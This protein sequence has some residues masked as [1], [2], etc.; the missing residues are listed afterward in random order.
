MSSLVELRKVQ[1]VYSQVPTPVLAEVNL[2]ITPG[3]R[4][5]ILGASG[6]GKTT[7]LHLLGL[8]LKADEGQ[9]L[10]D[11]A[12]AQVWSEHKR[13][14]WRR[15]NLGYVFQD[16]GLIPELTLEE[17]V[18]L[19]LRIAGIKS[20]AGLAKELLAQVGL[21]GRRKSFPSEVSGGESQRVAIAR[22]LIGQPKIVLADE[23]TGNLQRQQGEEI[24][25]LFRK[26]Q[27]ELGFSLVVATH[28]E[29]I[30][31]LLQARVFRLSSGS[32]ECQGNG[33]NAQ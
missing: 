5:V 17:N 27:H 29:E 24:A 19:P 21:A 9:V 6:S 10:M 30:A 13:A 20:Q 4:L 33:G 2:Q 11:G 26:L 25:N 32:L 28:N 18:E 22:A 1:K 7:L 12:D 23:P 16:F 8:L 31:E 3:E 14:S 15:S